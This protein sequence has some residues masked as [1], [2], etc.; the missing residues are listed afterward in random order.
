[1]RKQPLCHRPVRNML[2]AAHMPTNLPRVSETTLGVR[3]GGTRHVHAPI[4]R[5]VTYEAIALSPANG[6]RPL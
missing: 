2:L 4:L 5:R 3:P 6:L 1:M